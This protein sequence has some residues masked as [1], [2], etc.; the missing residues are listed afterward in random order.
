MA[1]LLD[2]KPKKKPHRCRAP[3]IMRT[4]IFKLCLCVCNLDVGFDAAFSLFLT[5]HI[6]IS[7]LTFSK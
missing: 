1:P 5:Y 6:R 3:G 4:F 7:L 2:Q